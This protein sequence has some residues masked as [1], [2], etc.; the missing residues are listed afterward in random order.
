[1]NGLSGSA[2]GAGPDI[3][4]R[5]L[6][7]M[8][9][10]LC[11]AAGAG[12][13]M[14]AG[15][16]AGRATGAAADVAANTAANL[17]ES[18]AARRG[19][20]LLAGGDVSALGWMERSGARYSDRA[21]K[22]RDALSILRDAGHN[23]V[24]LR[25]YVDPGRGR[26]NEGWHWPQDSMN[27]PDL[28][29]LARRS[30]ALG[31]QIQLTLHYSDFW[32]NGKTQIVPAA[33]RVQLD[34]L[35]TEEA[36]FERLRRLVFEHARDVMA[37]M[38]AQGTTPQFVSV[39]NEIEGG[40]LYPYGAMTEKNWPRLGALLQAGYEGVKAVSPASRVILHL[41]DAGNMDKYRNYFDHLRALGVQ[42]DVTGASYYPFWTKRTV[43]Q[44]AG[45]A[46]AVTAR[47]D[48]DLFVME[49]GFNW[50]PTLPNGHPG[51]LSDNGPYPAA[52]SSPAGQQAFMDELLSAMRGT[53]RV[54]G[55][56]YWDP[57]MIESPGV[58]WALRDSDGRAG[59]NVVSNTTLFD[60]EGRAL[61]V[62][63]SWKDYTR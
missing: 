57:I 58:G 14:A 41:D 31:M 11:A 56:L 19:G 49:A 26:G 6:L 55:V 8:A 47:Y 36:R 1:M 32:T 46:R 51:Q 63:D 44:L 45:F 42:W 25:L 62:L 40:M 10:A 30:A 39:G 38:K 37:A 22:R 23:I 18:A 5:R 53:E 59:P 34:K 24:R 29:A 28:L 4:R 15:L 21:G 61:P 3:G 35:A 9:A 54:L 20:P 27:L 43:A 12:G 52:M 48:R 16:D 13:S 2:A 33:W 17:A 60:F 50:S 7:G